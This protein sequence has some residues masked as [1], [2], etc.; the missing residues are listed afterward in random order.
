MT[1]THKKKTVNRN[2]SWGKKIVKFVVVYLK[3]AIINIW[4]ELNE[5]CLNTYGKFKM[6][7]HYIE[8]KRDRYYKKE[9]NR[10]SGVEK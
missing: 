4:K 6:I 8:E 7:S 9:T 5:S 10:I 1:H 2:R 3:S